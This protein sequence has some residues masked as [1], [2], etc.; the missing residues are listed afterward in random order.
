MYH[1]CL[2]FRMYLVSNDKTKNLKHNFQMLE[3]G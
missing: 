3:K 1:Y 2:Q